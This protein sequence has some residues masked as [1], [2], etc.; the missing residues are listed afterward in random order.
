MAYTN[1]D[2]AEEAVREVRMR[3]R[4][5]PRRVAEGK[6]DAASA[7]RQIRIMQEIAEDYRT[8]AANGDL[9]D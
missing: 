9:F 2:K 1:Q 7:E 8:L 6:L 5:Y 3:E 4:V